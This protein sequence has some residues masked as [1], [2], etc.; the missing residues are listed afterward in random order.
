MTAL[1]RASAI[2]SFCSEDH[3]GRDSGYHHLA[4]S[5]SS[6]SPSESRE[7]GRTETSSSGY[8]P[9]FPDNQEKTITLNEGESKVVNVTARGNPSAIT[10]K[11]KKGKGKFTKTSSAIV[12][13]PLL[14]FKNITRD[15]AGTYTCTAEN[16]NGKTSR[17]IKIDVNY[18]PTIEKVEETLLFPENAP[19]AKLICAGTANPVK[20]SMISW[21]RDDYDLAARGKFTTEIRART[22][23]FVS[24]LT[25]Y[26]LKRDDTGVFYC[27]AKNSIGDEVKE[28][29]KLLV[30]YGPVM[31]TTPQFQKAASDIGFPVTLKCRAT[32]APSISFIWQREGEKLNPGDM[33]SI[34]TKKLADDLITWDTELT[35]GK[36]RKEDFGSYTC[37]GRNSVGDSVT[38][39]YLN[40]TSA[41]DAARTLEAADVTHESITVKWEPGFDGGFRQSFVLKYRSPEQSIYTFAEVNGTEYTVFGLK[42][43]QKYYFDIKA[44]NIKGDSEFLGE[45][46]ATTRGYSPS[47]VGPPIPSEPSQTEMSQLLVV[48]II[49]GVVVLVAIN[50]SL[51][52]C[53][54]NRRRRP[55]AHKQAPSEYGGRRNPAIQMYTSSYETYPTERT[56]DTVSFTSEK[57]QTSATTDNTIAAKRTYLLDDGEVAPHY[58]APTTRMAQTLPH[59]VPMSR[60]ATERE[61][62]RHDDDN[63]YLDMSG[64]LNSLPVYANGFHNGT[65]GLQSILRGRHLS[66]AE[67]ERPAERRPVHLGTLPRSMGSTKNFEWRDIDGTQMQRDRLMSFPSRNQFSPV[68]GSPV[69]STFQRPF[70]PEEFVHRQFI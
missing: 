63:Q 55:H 20:E 44:R 27:L 28:S 18:P 2:T 15:D 22:K 25:I 66:D 50:I 42:P 35:I 65:L 67:D 31:D 33:Y 46:S 38:S 51:V 56:G 13:G 3:T 23:E 60:F 1:Y 11:W 7:R 45:I 61:P 14:E 10:Y 17:K 12:D 16:S 41:P 43:N 54:I 59:V 30:E 47:P 70:R 5:D 21:T 32:G 19:E 26:N 48:A 24:T 49:V 9:E 37:H 8:K 39:I 62:R 4:P 53:V 36:V 69:M 40:R 57:S 6:Q 68:V 34:E 58:S 64:Q 52:S 29:R